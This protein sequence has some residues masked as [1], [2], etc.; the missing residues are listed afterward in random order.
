MTE[1]TAKQIAFWL[2]LET[3]KNSLTVQYEGT[4]TGVG[5][6]QVPVYREYVDG[7]GYFEEGYDPNTMCYDP[8]KDTDVWD[9]YFN[10]DPNSRGLIPLG[11]VIFEC[12]IEQVKKENRCADPEAEPSA[13]ICANLPRDI[14]EA[15]DDEYELKG[16]LWSFDPETGRW[17]KPI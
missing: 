3:E 5:I 11:E 2:V 16:D 1:Q 7:T 4:L 13:N 14:Q 12:R 17:S 8:R 10:E 15:D 6:T 9:K